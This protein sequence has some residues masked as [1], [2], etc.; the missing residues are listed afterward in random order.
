MA[1]IFSSIFKEKYMTR[2]EEI[3]DED[4]KNCSD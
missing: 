4:E 1:V 2:D 3:K